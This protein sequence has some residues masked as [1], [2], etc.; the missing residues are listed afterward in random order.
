M[1]SANYLGA[2]SGSS[3]AGGNQ[4]P[5]KP[6]RHRHQNLLRKRR[7]SS[8]NNNNN[9]INSSQV[10]SSND[11]LADA[12]YLDRASLLPNDQ[13]LLRTGT[14][15]SSRQVAADEIS[16]AQTTMEQTGV[17]EPKVTILSVHLDTVVDQRTLVS[18]LT[19][20][21]LLEELHLDSMKLNLTNFEPDL[22]PNPADE[23][24]LAK[25]TT[26]TMSHL[27]HSAANRQSPAT[28]SSSTQQLM[29]SGGGGQQQEQQQ[30]VATPTMQQQA[31]PSVQLAANGGGPSTVASVSTKPV[32]SGTTAAPNTQLLAANSNPST[33]TTTTT[34]AQIS[35]GRT[36]SAIS[37]SRVVIATTG[38]PTSVTTT[39]PVTSTTVPTTTTTTTSTTPPTTLAASTLK[40]RN[41][42]QPLSLKPI[43]F[44]SSS[45][46]SSSQI[47]GGPR[48]L[49]IAQATGIPPT[50]A[51]SAQQQQQQTGGAPT[52][53]APSATTTI[54]STTVPSIPL[55]MVVSSNQQN[56]HLL[57]Q[58]SNGGPQTSTSRHVSV[59]PGNISVGSSQS[60]S[61]TYISSSSSSSPTSSQ[62]GRTQ[63]MMFQNQPPTT[64]SQLISGT[65][66]REQSQLTPSGRIQVS[67]TGWLQSS[68]SSNSL[69][70]PVNLP[71]GT[72]LSQSESLQQ[73]ASQTN[74]IDQLQQIP[75][76][77]PSPPHWQGTSSSNLHLAPTSTATT[78]TS[79]AT[80]GASQQSVGLNTP[81][82]SPFS[83]STGG[84]GVRTSVSTGGP[85][86]VSM[87]LFNGQNNGGGGG[88]FRLANS[89]THQLGHTG[90]APNNIGL[91]GI[92]LNNQFQTSTSGMSQPA[93]S[94]SLAQQSQPRRQQASINQPIQISSTAQPA[95][96]S[97][98][99]TTTTTTTTTINNENQ[100]SFV[101]AGGRLNLPHSNQRRNQHLG[102][103]N[104]NQLLSTSGGGGGGSSSQRH[105]L[106]ATSRSEDYL[107]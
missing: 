13:E 25:T 37:S 90:G 31:A 5:L 51:Q 83:T 2:G 79:S 21:D 44:S 55:S 18:L 72:R 35:N 80:N 98:P 15:L 76:T 67:P 24:M 64:S 95:P 88:A 30:Q 8:G 39:P 38:A 107:S 41:K 86:P 17:N 92:H 27:S 104:G 78:G 52:T 59:P 65:S 93:T 66:Q 10:R 46:R 69:T 36:Q 22:E 50:T 82:N 101:A 97:P 58:Q 20:L 47:L 19:G 96:P 1:Q 73:A 85:L 4:S 61:I 42:L 33:T 43:Q 100:Q 54:S 6:A 56:N 89:Q 75:S 57:R 7:S 26:T 11:E 3:I 71:A 84:F 87:S 16:S 62:S 14:R 29:P 91:R 103:G 102:I 74:Q 28:S 77:S 63:S 94:V 49:T 40:P 32:G 106:T 9:E 105:S 34:T 99:T 48:G 70:T 81:I 45:S 68:S 23:E 53:L 60:Q 12:A